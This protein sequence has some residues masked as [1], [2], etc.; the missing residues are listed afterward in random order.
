[1]PPSNFGFHA[2]AMRG[3]KSLYTMSLRIIAM[4]GI[5]RQH[6]DQWI[7]DLAVERRLLPL[8]QVNLRI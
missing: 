8:L 3:A 6:S 2:T 4:E 1:M 5:D 7:I